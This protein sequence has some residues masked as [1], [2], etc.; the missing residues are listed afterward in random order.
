MSLEYC[1]EAVGVARDAI[2]SVD[3][4]IDR[5]RKSDKIRFVWQ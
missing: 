5:F 1:S 4:A 3:T 2:G